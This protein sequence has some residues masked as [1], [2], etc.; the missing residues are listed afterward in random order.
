MIS[1]SGA[2]RR[3]SRYRN[4]GLSAAIWLV[5]CCGV[6]LD[7]LTAQESG[8]SAK[9]PPEHAKARKAN[10][11]A[12]ESSPYLLQ[13]AYNPVNWRPW[14]AESLAAAKRE[15]KIIFLSIGYSSC[16]WCHVMER[17]SF[18]DD[19]IAAYL[20]EHFICIKVD[21]EERPDIDSIYMTSLQVYNQMTR[22]GRGG[23]WPL[24]M[25]LTPDAKPFVGGSYFP[26]RDG[27]RGFGTGFLTLIRRV[28]D[29]WKNAP[30]RI[31]SDAELITRVLREELAGRVAADDTVPASGAP[32]QAALER[33]QKDFDPKY[34]GFRFQEDN[35]AVPKFPEASN[36]VFLL[37]QL[38]ATPADQRDAHPAGKLLNVTLRSMQQGGIWD[39]VGGG[40]HR[41]SVDRFWRIPH[42]EKMLYDNGQLL[43]VYA[44]AYELTG[45][46]PYREACL[47]VIEFVEREMTSPEGGFYSALDADSEGE[48]GKFYRW[49]LQEA[50]AVLGPDHVW[51]DIYGLT[52]PPNFE[53]H[54]HAPQLQRGIDDEALTRRIAPKQLR[55]QLDDARAKL[56]AV[57]SKRVRPLT[58]TKILTAWNGLMIRGLA[59][60]GRILK[61]PE[62]IKLAVRAADFLLEKMP[63]ASGRLRRSYSKDQARL[64]AYLDDYA[65]LIDGLLA[66]HQATEEPRWLEEA[67]KLQ[68]KQ[69]ELFW[70]EEHGGYFFTSQGHETLLVRSKNPIDGAIPSGS[71][72]AVSN[73]LA[74]AKATGDAALRAKA[75]RV[76]QASATLLN[77]RPSAVIRLSSEL[78]RTQQ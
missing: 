63:D 34:G 22:N 57:R 60:A 52:G 48:E 4:A 30:D 32:A 64:N 55:K 39:H 61:E 69:D 3:A 35:P 50:R 45:E 65:M 12:G 26:A 67:Q 78:A 77:R 29:I 59:D 38:E 33:L 40:F 24:S 2:R 76:F 27:D 16:H 62:P 28:R 5:V 6:T 49:T 31:Q 44:R 19:E 20:N 42:F 37:D 25:F 71:S 17:E 43:S 74:L 54:W 56:L 58:D 11:L 18:E 68:A 14:N 72:I 23:G 47:G 51:C 9:S 53:E 75:D 73:L 46:R 41:Y 66:L 1:K 8:G 70:D 13:H 36:L 21:R 10:Q 7:P 15:N